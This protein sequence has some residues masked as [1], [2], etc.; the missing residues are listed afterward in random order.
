MTGHLTDADCVRIVHASIHKDRVLGG[1]DGPDADVLLTTV[2]QIVARHRAE[3]L[4][5]AADAIR[6]ARE[7]RLDFTGLDFHPIGQPFED[8]L[9]DRADR[10]ARP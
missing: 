4:R 7:G 6:A 5:E 9:R 2:E 10:E 8:W 1:P 3:A